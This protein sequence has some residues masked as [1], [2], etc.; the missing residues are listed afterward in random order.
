MPT[1]YCDDCQLPVNECSENC[2]GHMERDYRQKMS[3]WEQ[4]ADWIEGMIY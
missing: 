3:E 2:P 4:S 1:R